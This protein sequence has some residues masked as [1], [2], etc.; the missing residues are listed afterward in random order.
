M[1]VMMR[2]NYHSVGKKNRKKRLSMMEFPQYY[3]Y[4]LP[5]KNKIK[6]SFGENIIGE[7]KLFRKVSTLLK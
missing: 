2:R 6:C 7:A 3:S 5:A 1:I 4:S